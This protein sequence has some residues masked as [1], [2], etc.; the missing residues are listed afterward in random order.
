MGIG[1]FVL[2]FRSIA[3]ILQIVG[4]NLGRQKWS[5]IDIHRS[6]KLASYGRKRSRPATERTVKLG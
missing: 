4:F 2:A 5:L 6:P 1:G 3:Q